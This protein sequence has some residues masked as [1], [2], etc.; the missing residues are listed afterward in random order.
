MSDREVGVAG[1]LT[2]VAACLS[3]AVVGLG[4][5]AVELLAAIV[6]SLAIVFL[7]V[8]LGAPEAF[9]VGQVTLVATLPSP[10]PIGPALLAEGALFALLLE[11]DLRM[12]SRRRRVLLMVLFGIVVGGVGWGTL[13][14]WDRLWA[15]SVVLLGTGGLIAYLFHRYEYVQ[16]DVVRGE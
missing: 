3:L 12:A 2:T 1:W 11:P 7:R 6:G 10:V 5:G 16:L 14:A 15:T 4:G 8:R 13:V 9:A